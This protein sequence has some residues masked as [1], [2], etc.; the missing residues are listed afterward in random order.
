MSEWDKKPKETN[1]ETFKT[2]LEE[3]AFNL[4]KD[5]FEQ[6]T[7]NFEQQ[8]ENF[9]KKQT[10]S[11]SNL[12]EVLNMLN[13]TNRKQQKK[14][15]MNSENN[16]TNTKLNNENEYKFTK[17]IIENCIYE[18]LREGFSKIVLFLNYVTWYLPP[19]PPPPQTFS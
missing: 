9:E 18:K 2:F 14:S 11:M 7:E 5:N 3:P 16:E 12:F 4:S 1:C 17:Y 19:T 6:Q 10:I 13:T 15:P 8:T